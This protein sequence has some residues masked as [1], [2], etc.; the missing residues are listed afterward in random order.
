MIF[1]NRSRRGEDP[2]LDWKVRLFLVGAVVALVGMARDATWMVLGGMLILLA[3][4]SLRFFPGGR[5]R[6]PSPEDDEDDGQS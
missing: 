3:G 5:A 2:Y 4:A 1:L 6:G